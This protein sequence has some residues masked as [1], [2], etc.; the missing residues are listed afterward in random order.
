MR[1]VENNELHN[2]I[3][4]AF[5]RLSESMCGASERGYSW[6][7]VL[8]Y[9]WETAES[10]PNGLLGGLA[11]HAKKQIDEGYIKM[12]PCIYSGICKPAIVT[13]V[14]VIGDSLYFA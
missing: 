9:D 5:M 8:E 13:V 4:M 6:N 12:S 14:I 7:A 11:Q 2:T 10:S 3:K 1:H